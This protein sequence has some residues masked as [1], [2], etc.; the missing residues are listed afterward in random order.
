MSIPIP[1]GKQYFTGSQLN[2]PPCPGD[3]IYT[4]W[5]STAISTD[6]PSRCIPRS[7]TLGIDS[8]YD[9]LRAKSPR[10][11]RNKTRSTNS[12]SVNT[13]LVSAC[14][15]HTSH[16][17]DTTQPSTNGQRNEN[18]FRNTFDYVNDGIASLRSCPNI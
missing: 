13:D 11:L 6:F 10:P 3:S 7:P 2:S 8:H 12:S 9:T 5:Y 14:L 4:C 1:T 17:T 16:I 18:L 15:K